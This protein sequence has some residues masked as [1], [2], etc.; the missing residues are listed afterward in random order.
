MKYLPLLLLLVFRTL[1]MAQT[2]TPGQSYFGSNDYIEY[3][4]GN[5]PIVVTAP[6][7]GY[8]TPDTIPDRDCTGCSYARDVNTQE[9]VR[10]L[11][12]RLYERTG[13]YPHTIINRLH[14]RKLDA[15]REVIE[16]ADG[17]PL[18]EQAWFDFHRFIN[19]AADSVAAHFPKGFYVDMH[20]HG[21]DIQRLELG[22]LLTK[23]ELLL[24]DSVIDLSDYVEESS[25]KR[26]VA[27]NLQNL[28]HAAL[29]RGPQGFGGLVAPQGYPAV[30][31]PQ[32]TFPEPAEPYFNG[33][34]NTNRYCNSS[35]NVLSGL[36]I[37]AHYTGLRD[38][39]AN[40][41]RFADSL[42]VSIL[43]F[44]EL[45]YFPMPTGG[46]CATPSSSAAATPN[47]MDFKVFPNPAIGQFTVQV[48]AGTPATG[49]LEVVNLLGQC[50]LQ[51]P[52][53]PDVTAYPMRLD[54]HGLVAVL[55]KSPEGAICRFLMME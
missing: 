31:S 12:V 42:A 19:H 3:I 2:Y 44:L 40:I 1:G 39:T 48:P 29:I 38:N 4:P 20:G 17:N 24:P 13:C 25:L 46:W 7:G 41:N 18:A 37:E 28:S 9:L 15:N 51:C 11:S 35:D 50:L 34:Y 22:Y 30:P 36:Q 23:T 45:H 14:R 26:L 52:L 27:N 5:L 54:Y 49:R 53:Q 47:T 43:R 55:L 10:A 16:A 21:H 32:D 33:G 6:H 8:L